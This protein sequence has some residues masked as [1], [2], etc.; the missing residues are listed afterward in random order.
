MRNIPPPA[1]EPLFGAF[2][3]LLRLYDLSKD[4]FESLAGFVHASHAGWLII[5]GSGVVVTVAALI[6]TGR[7]ARATAAR[8]AGRMMSDEPMVPVG[9][10]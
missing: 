6:T 9:T 10:L 1:N 7:W 2:R 4:A 5:A 3:T 8:T